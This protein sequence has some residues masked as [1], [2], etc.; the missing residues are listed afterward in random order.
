MRI[1]AESGPASLLD[2]LAAAAAAAPLALPDLVALPPASL[3]SAITRGLVWPLDNHLTEPLTD[4]WFAFAQDFAT[5]ADQTYA[6]PFA[7]DVLALAYSPAVLA[8]APESWAASLELYGPLA[9]ASADPQALYP[10]A[11]YLGRGGRLADDSGRATL[12]QEQLRAVL[13][14]FEQASQTGL[15]PVSLT[16]YDSPGQAWA[17]VNEGR[18]SMAVIWLSTLLQNN[19]NGLLAAALP[20]HNGQPFTLATGWAW[21]LANPESERQALAVELAE[22]LTAPEFLAAWSEAAGVLPTRPSAL[23]PGEPAALAARLLPSAQLLPDP[24]LLERTA[25]QIAEAVLAVLK[26]ASSPDDAAAQAAE[27]FLP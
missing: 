17:A 9:F 26:R 14:Y 8:A 25:P 27:P 22:F 15:M 18:A 7:A 5:Q 3:H 1:K 21:A 2:S 12:E 20:T 11:L 10:L 16:Q 24:A 23:P 4:D 19:P 6:L 13:A